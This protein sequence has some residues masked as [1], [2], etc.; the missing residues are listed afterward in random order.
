MRLDWH[1]PVPRVHLRV[2]R[3]DW[4]VPPC[5]TVWK[6][7][8]CPG[9]IICTTIVHVSDVTCS[10]CHRCHMGRFAGE[11][12]CLE[13]FLLPD[14]FEQVFRH[15]SHINPL[16]PRCTKI[17]PNAC[18]THIDMICCNAVR[19]LTYVFRALLMIPRYYLFNA[20]QE[21]NITPINNV[22]MVFFLYSTNLIDNLFFSHWFILIE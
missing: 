22:F 5:L 21:I 13:A 15:D 17:T 6:R 14:C 16:F 19:N 1:V 7:M 8:I 2:I 3:T 20:N 12:D 9:E 11:I 4:S 10:R 18:K